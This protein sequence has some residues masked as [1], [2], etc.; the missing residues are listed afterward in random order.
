MAHSY[1][2]KNRIN[3]LKDFNLRSVVLTLRDEVI[4]EDVRVPSDHQLFNYSQKMLKSNTEKN[5]STINVVQKL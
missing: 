4:V 1:T 2:T 3:V 5:G